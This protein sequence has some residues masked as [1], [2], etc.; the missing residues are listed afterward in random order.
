MYGCHGLGCHGCHG[1]HGC[2]YVMYKSTCIEQ[3]GG[4]VY[5]WREDGTASSLTFSVDVAATASS[6][7]VKNDELQ[8]IVFK[9]WFMMICD[10]NVTST[11]TVCGAE[12]ETS[13]CVFECTMEKGS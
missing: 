8:N 1:C 5:S 13:Q 10:T 3:L 7:P 2:M 11:S 9:N 6:M 4:F 12:K